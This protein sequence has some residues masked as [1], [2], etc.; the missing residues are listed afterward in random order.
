MIVN[1]TDKPDLPW[2]PRQVE[3][4]TIDVPIT[5]PRMLTETARLLRQHYYFHKIPETWI[6]IPK[7]DNSISKV[8]SSLEEFN[9]YMSNQPD[10][11]RAL[12]PIVSHKQLPQAI[13]FFL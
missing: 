8:P 11:T 4:I 5:T 6:E 2:D 12:F 13:Q 10:E 9:T 1:L 7:D 3:H